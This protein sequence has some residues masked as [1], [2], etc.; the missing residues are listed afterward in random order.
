MRALPPPFR[1]CKRR[2]GESYFEID[3][4]TRSRTQ[5]S[6]MN[7]LCIDCRHSK[8]EW[9]N[10]DQPTYPE[11]PWAW[12]STASQIYRA[13]DL[14]FACTPIRQGTQLLQCMEAARR[15]L[16]NEAYGAFALQQS[17]NIPLRAMAS[18]EHP[19]SRMH[20]DKVT[21][22]SELKGALVELDQHVPLHP[23]CLAPW[24]TCHVQQAVG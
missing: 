20:G 24:P 1:L 5:V 11:A 14:A 12:T 17:I 21:R 16:H 19:T 15:Q 7:Q 13:F 2:K 3:R 22:C 8:F 9:E 10:I 4:V 18:I 6:S 23:L